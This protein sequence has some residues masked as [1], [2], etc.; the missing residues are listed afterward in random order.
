MLSASE[1]QSE[2][3][4]I[5]VVDDNAEIRRYVREIL[6]GQGYHILEAPDG[7]EA[8]EIAQPE[9]PAIDLVLTDLIMPRLNG[10]KLARCLGE[11]RPQTP[12][13]YMSGYVES[14]LLAAKYPD[15]LLLQKPFTPSRLVAAVE[16]VMDDHRQPAGVHGP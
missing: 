13:L 8:L 7:A 10:V 15:A 1:Q 9:G 5:L 2:L 4:T 6:E 14:G 16:K 11:L 12:V 3:T